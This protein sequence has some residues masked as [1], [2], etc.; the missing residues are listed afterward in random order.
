MSV[1]V[2]V[3]DCVYICV[4]VNEKPFA[5]GKVA[6]TAVMFTAGMDPPQCLSA[7]Y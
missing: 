1:C 2:C 3:C 6:F 7:A 5:L 4:N